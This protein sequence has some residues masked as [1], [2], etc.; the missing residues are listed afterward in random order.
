MA[1]LTIEEVEHIASLSKLD[2]SDE[3]KKIYSNQLS[4][5]LSY[6]AQLAE[7]NTDNTEPLSNV[8]G[9]ENVMRDDSVVDY[10]FGYDDIEKNAPGFSG[11]SFVVPGVFE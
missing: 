1:K 7:V 9:L 4:D 3:E 10:G 2:L 6:V 5:V 11:G 8:T